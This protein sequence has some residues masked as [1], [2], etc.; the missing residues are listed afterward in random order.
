MQPTKHPL[1]P[2]LLVDNDPDHSLW[3]IEKNLISSGYNHLE[4]CHKTPS[5]FKQLA[6]HPVNVALIHVRSQEH[7]NMDLF[8]SIIKD[9]PRL[10]LIAIVD[11]QD[12]PQ[13]ERCMKHGAFDYIIKPVEQNRMIHVIRHAIEAHELRSINQ[14]LQNKLLN[15][16]I[17]NHQAFS[18]IITQNRKM[19]AIINYIESISQSS[20]PVFLSGESGSGKTTLAKAAHEVTRSQCP[21]YCV[22][23]A[24]LDDYAFSE[25]LFG[26]HFHF[27]NSADGIQKGLVEK[28]QNGSLLIQNIDHLSLISQNKL[29]RL[30]KDN[31]YIPLGADKKY[32]STVRI[33]VTGNTDLK[34]M[35]ENGRFRK[36]LIY[37][38]THHHIQVP[39]LRERIDDIP[40][41]I[42]HFIENAAIQY[43]K[44]IP[45]PPKE[46]ATLLETYPFPG[47]VREL[48]E[49]I[50]EAVQQHKNGILSTQVFRRT[51]STSRHCHK[52]TLFSDL[53]ESAF[54]MVTFSKILPTL[55][56][57]SWL[58][59]AE[60]MRR[61][62]G[63]QSIASHLLG[64]SQ[65]ALSKRL[66][67]MEA[68]RIF[69]R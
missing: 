6:T 7:S 47:N 40:L 57:T 28:A 25:T 16:P 11:R 41:L 9:Y 51:L 37:Q 59:I 17:S 49:L 3:D 30:M 39:P 69:V 65:Q 4:V 34:N 67:N 54:G 48:K 32:K 19:L 10:S 24:K 44:K 29:L 33:I 12:I 23:A 14:D 15:L 53:K 58:V 36:D 27:M 31:E 64:I 46:L 13:G 38:L 2:I 56:Q 5:V 61:A 45:T 1:H 8:R 60:A 62:K 66:Q 43:Q 18:N 35:E 52:N 63:N 22:D 68:K 42:H 26:Q 21:I 55:K 20:R 50:F